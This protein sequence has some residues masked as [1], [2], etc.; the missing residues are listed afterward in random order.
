MKLTLGALAS[1]LLL[2]LACANTQSPTTIT[3]RVDVPTGPP[4]TAAFLGVTLSPLGDGGTSFLY[5][6]SSHPTLDAA[7]RTFVVILPDGGGQT[8][9]V[10]VE[11]LAALPGD[12]A[13]PPAPL[14]RGEASVTTVSHQ[15]VEVTVHLSPPTM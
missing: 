15:D 5:D 14:G 13:G 11:A 7:G 2:A 12:D 4:V 8:L 9:D 3:V 1:V 10:V 6:T